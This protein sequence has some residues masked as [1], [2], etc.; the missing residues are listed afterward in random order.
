MLASSSA[1]AWDSAKCSK[2]LNNGLYATYKWGGVGDS[3]LNA[4]TGETKKTNSASASSKISV[5]GT[6]AVLDPKYSSNISTSNTQGTSSW[7]D[8]SLFAL[9]KRKEQRDLYLAQNGDQVKVDIAKGYGGH[10]EALSWFSLCDDQ[11]ILEFNSALQTEMKSLVDA[12][13]QKLSQSIDKVIFS[14]KN[15]KSGCYNLSS[16]K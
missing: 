8:C 7:G 6:T 13:A 3:N 2:M 5:E 1:F 14:H 10:L 15:L 16:I 11:V 4:M 12:H 9:Q